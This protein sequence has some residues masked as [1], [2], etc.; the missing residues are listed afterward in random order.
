MILS[1]QIY[2]KNNFYAG[3]KIQIN[4]YF[5]FKTLKNNLLNYFT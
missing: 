1:K 5:I 3:K 4:F 2:I